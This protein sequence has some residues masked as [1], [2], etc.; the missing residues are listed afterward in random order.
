[1]TNTRIT[2]PEVLELR[3]PVRLEKF[4]IRRG[5]GGKGTFNGG[6]G[7]IREITFLE[8][9][10]LSLLSQHRLIFPYGIKGGDKG[11]TGRQHIVRFDGS[12]QKLDGI[13]EAILN[14]GDRLVIETPGGGGFG[15]FMPDMP[16]RSGQNHDA[17]KQ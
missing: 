10:E 9:V 2:D 1:M 15:D 17:G 5:S 3:Y 13:A 12:V 4:E 16:R 7:A 8:Q 14:K 11:M 6:N